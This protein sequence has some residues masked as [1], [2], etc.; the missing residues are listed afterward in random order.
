MSYKQPESKAQNQENTNLTQNLSTWFQT[1]RISFLQSSQNLNGNNN[2]KTPS[3]LGNLMNQNLFINFHQ[4][5]SQKSL[6]TLKRNDL[7][8]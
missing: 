2:P 3:R 6:K 4:I 5:R 1:P 7:D 8:N